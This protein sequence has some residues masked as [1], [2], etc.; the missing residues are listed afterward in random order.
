MLRKRQFTILHQIVLGLSRLDLRSQLDITTSEI[1]IQDSIG[2]T[3]LHWA[4]FTS[5]IPAVQ[6]LLEYGARL[7]IF[8]KRKI[9]IFH[10]CTNKHKDDNQAA[11]ALLLGAF[12][13]SENVF[14]G[15]V[16]ACRFLENPVAHL[17]TQC[18]TCN[19]GAIKK[20]INHQSK[21]G[22]TALCNTAF[23]NIY[24]D[25]RLL[26]AHGALV[27]LGFNTIPLLIAVQFKS[28]QL[29]KLLL[30]S[31]A[32]T[33]VK[34]GDGMNVLHMVAYWGDLESINILIS[35]KIKVVGHKDVDIYGHTP[36]KSITESNVPL[37]KNIEIYE[38]LSLKLL[39][40]F[41][42]KVIYELIS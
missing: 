7:D 32:E 24:N 40:N 26:L 17:T 9:S 33:E 25:A 38:S 31:G 29:L 19:I 3:P 37:Q 6:I 14:R 28:N 12:S 18:D 1:D 21:S 10:L 16:H 20:L 13:S 5:N 15:T 27:N 2:R 41:H 11:L 34:D 39:F 23:R 35:K 36:C 30:E 22:S 4:V 42:L 8:D